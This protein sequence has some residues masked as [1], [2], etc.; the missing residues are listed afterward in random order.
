MLHTLLLVL[1]VLVAI[2]LIT[3]ILLQQGRGAATGAAFGGGASSTVFGARGSASF[4]SRTTSILAVV[5]FA[6]CLL[7]AVLGGQRE[8]PRSVV[9]RISSA[10]V[11]APAESAVPASAESAAPTTAAGVATAPAQTARDNAAPDLPKIPATQSQ[12]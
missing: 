1:H 8:G 10:A 2:S 6:N 9:E 3:V 5:F 7:L 11:P 4:L 12:P